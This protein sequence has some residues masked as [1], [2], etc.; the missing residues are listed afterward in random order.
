MKITYTELMDM[1]IYIHMYIDIYMDIY[2]YIW[3]EISRWK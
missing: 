2:I 1:G 3:L